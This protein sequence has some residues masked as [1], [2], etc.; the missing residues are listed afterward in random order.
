MTQMTYWTQARGS[1]I[2]KDTLAD[3]ALHA[4][5]EL[6]AVRTTRR[7][8]HLHTYSASQAYGYNIVLLMVY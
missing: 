2:N 6:R 8:G 1:H 4:S 7:T 3:R 5:V